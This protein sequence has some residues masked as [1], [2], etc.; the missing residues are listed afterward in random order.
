MYNYWSWRFDSNFGPFY[1]LY[2]INI[3]MTDTL[4]GYVVFTSSYNI[5]ELISVSRRYFL[6]IVSF[7]I[8][9]YKCVFI[10]VYELKAW[11]R[12]NGYNSN[13]RRCVVETKQM[14]FSFPLRGQPY[15]QVS[16]TYVYIYKPLH[17]RPCPVGDDKFGI[18]LWPS[19][20]PLQRVVL[21]IIVRPHEGRYA[22]R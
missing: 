19:F 9:T 3:I 11:A 5:S 22:Y 16:Y 15:F 8:Y 6:H 14:A 10:Y 2:N 4:D 20:T 1:L 12:W 7:I 21:I 13:G 18:L 17:I